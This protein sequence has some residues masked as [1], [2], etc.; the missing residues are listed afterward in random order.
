[1]GAAKCQAKT[2]QLHHATGR[3]HRVLSGQKLSTHHHHHLAPL[4]LVVNLVGTNAY[5][6]WETDWHFLPQLECMHVRIVFASLW[7]IDGS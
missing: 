1:M 6:K 4:R 2:Y 7:N 3:T 5:A